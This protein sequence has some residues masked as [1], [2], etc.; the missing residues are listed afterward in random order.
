MQQFSQLLSESEEEFQ[1]SFT[2]SDSNSII[3]EKEAF[4]RILD[5]ID[6]K[7]VKSTKQFWMTNANLL[8]K[9]C[10]VALILMNIPSNSAFV[11]RFFSLCGIICHDK[12]GNMSDDLIINRAMIASN[13]RLIE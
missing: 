4:V 13:I 5:D 2:F 8:P 3:K 9:T 10:Q 6:L 12:A 1:Q 11:E 7:K